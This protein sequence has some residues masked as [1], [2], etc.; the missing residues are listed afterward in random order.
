MVLDGLFHG[1]LTPCVSN[2]IGMHDK[3]TPVPHGGQETANKEEA[4]PHAQQPA[5]SS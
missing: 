4:K 1:C 3:G 2:I 5:F